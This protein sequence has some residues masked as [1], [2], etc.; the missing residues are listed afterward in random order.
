M[1]EAC[2]IIFISLII[3]LKYHIDVEWCQNKPVSKPHSAKYHNHYS[4]FTP[5]TLINMQKHYQIIG[6]NHVGQKADLPTR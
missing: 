4:S 5:L 6:I 1:N 3:S 2:T